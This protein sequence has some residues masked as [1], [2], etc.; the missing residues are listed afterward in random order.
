MAAGSL[1]RDAPGHSTSSR[2]LSTRPVPSTRLA[3]KDRS[4]PSPSALSSACWTAEWGAVSPA[5]SIS[6]IIGKRSQGRLQRCPRLV[7]LA[8][9]FISASD[10]LEPRRHGRRDR[11]ESQ[12]LDP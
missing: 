8:A 5:S 4:I 6:V 10:Q 2:W 11:T 9:S 1:Y 12:S 3:Q 7:H